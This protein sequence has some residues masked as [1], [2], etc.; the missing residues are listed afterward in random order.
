MNS[1]LGKRFLVVATDDRYAVEVH[2]RYIAT[3]ALTNSNDQISRLD[4]ESRFQVVTSLMPKAQSTD[5][6]GGK[7]LK[8]LHERLDGLFG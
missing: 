2:S 4:S 5:E 8:E 7:V 6:E 1:S 3:T